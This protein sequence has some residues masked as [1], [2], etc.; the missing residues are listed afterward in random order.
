MSKRWKAILPGAFLAFG[1]CM[2][3]AFNAAR[4]RIIVLQSVG[5]ES[6]WAKG[7]DA[8]VRAALQS[9]RRPV[10]VEWQYLGVDTRSAAGVRATATFSSNESVAASPSEPQQTRALQPPSIMRR[11]WRASA[12]WSTAPLAR[13]LVVRAGMTPVQFMRVG[14]G[15]GERGAGQGARR[16]RAARRAGP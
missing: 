2:L 9:N 15:G 1:F 5:A 6:E 4:P 16:T 11:A 8:G 14:Q 10:S 13:R 3:V 7:V 12:G